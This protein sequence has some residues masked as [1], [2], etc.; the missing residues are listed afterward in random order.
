MGATLWEGRFWN[1]QNKGNNLQTPPK[2]TLL[3]YIKSSITFS[4]DFYL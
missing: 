2:D 3:F 4:D 1:V